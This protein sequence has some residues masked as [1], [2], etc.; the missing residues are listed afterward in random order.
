MRFIAVFIQTESMPDPNRM[1]FFP[2]KNVSKDVTPREF[3]I[4]EENAASP[5]ATRLFEIGGLSTVTLYEDCV[6]ITKYDDKEWQTL[7]P[8]ILGAIMDH[9][10]SG[11]PVL[12]GQD[13]NSDSEFAIEDKPEDESVINNIKEILESRIKPAADQMGGEV[14]YKGYK[15]GIVYVEFIG[16]TT[17][18]IQGMGNILSHYVNEV[19]AVRDFRDAIPKP[20]LDSEEAKEVLK[21][22]EEKI[23]PSVASHGGHVTL[24]DL[25]DDIAFIR[26]EGGCQGCGMAD[27]TLKNGIEVEIKGAVPTITS[28]LDVTDHA[29]GLNP[30]YAPN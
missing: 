16:P 26:L 30:Y 4:N 21:V 24:I 17:A 12:R 22:L 15:D 23:N 13:D 3:Q 9:Y 20:G 25:K 29:E 7:K 18:L 14:N 2:G 28:V 8:M 27:A 5:L 6:M 11:E 19:T 10:V 1:K